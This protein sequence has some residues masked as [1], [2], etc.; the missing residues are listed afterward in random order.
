M[1]TIACSKI[2]IKILLKRAK[3]FK[4]EKNERLVPLLLTLNIFTGTVSPR[5]SLLS[6]K[7][8]METPEQSVE[9]VH[10]QQ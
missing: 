8:K 2:D 7:L 9:S 4:V 10:S 1:K 6:L 5:W 3:L